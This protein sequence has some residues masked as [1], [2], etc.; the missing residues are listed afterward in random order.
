MEVGVGI[1]RAMPIAIPIAMPIA[2]PIAIPMAIPIPIPIPMPIPILRR[3]NRTGFGGKRRRKSGTG[4]GD[5][6]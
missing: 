3:G 1:A 5:G 2:M 4:E 6:K